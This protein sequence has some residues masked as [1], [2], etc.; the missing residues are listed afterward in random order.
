MPDGDEQLAGDG[1]EDF[2]LVLLADLGLM[3]GEAAEEAV[4]RPACSPGTLNDGLA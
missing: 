3:V 1:H 4:L 2:H